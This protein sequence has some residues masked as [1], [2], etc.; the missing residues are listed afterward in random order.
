MKLRH[1]IRESRNGWFLFLWDD[2]DI[3]IDL[4]RLSTFIATNRMHWTSL[5]PRRRPAAGARWRVT[6]GPFDAAWMGQ[7]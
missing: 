7:R 2:V 1:K 5:R 3:R 4:G 6:W